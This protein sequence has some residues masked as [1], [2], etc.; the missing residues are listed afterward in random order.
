MD[1]QYCVTHLSLQNQFD[2]YVSVC[3]MSAFYDEKCI[4]AGAA[5]DSNIPG[6][7]KYDLFSKIK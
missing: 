1:G 5:A 3:A 2:L 6:Q 7:S 4:I